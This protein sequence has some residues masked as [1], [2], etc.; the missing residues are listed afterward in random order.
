MYNR[1]V[2]RLNNIFLFCVCVNIYTFCLLVRVR[3]APDARRRYITRCIIKQIIVC[4]DVSKPAAESHWGGNETEA[5]GHCFTCS[6]I[7]TSATLTIY[8]AAMRAACTRL[9]FSLQ[10]LPCATE[11]TNTHNNTSLML[12][13]KTNFENHCSMCL[14]FCSC[15]HV[16]FYLYSH[17]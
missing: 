2:L 1:V 9:L 4:N 17:G 10:L 15:V 16:Y 5:I 6:R 7:H 8:H 14:R 13:T 3:A 12:Y 11:S